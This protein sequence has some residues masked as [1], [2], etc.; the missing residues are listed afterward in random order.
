M[1]IAIYG[2]LIKKDALPYVQQMFDELYARKISSYIHEDYYPHLINNIQFREQPVL[3]NE[4]NLDVIAR[5]DY[6]FSL[7]GDGTLLDTMT[8]VRN[9]NIPVVGINIGRLGFLANVGKDEIVSVLDALEKG[10]VTHDP[11]TLIHL[12]SNVPG[13]FGEAPFALNE[14]TIHKKDSSAM[15][16]IHTYI[17]GEFLMSYWADGLIVSTP[18]GSTGYSLSCGGPI[19]FPGSENFVITPVAPHNLNIRPIVVSD[20]SVISFEIEGRSDHFLVTLDSRYESVDSSIQLAVRKEDFTVT[21]I[22]PNEQHFLD[23]LRN[24]LSLG[25]DQRN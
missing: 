13:L 16:V 18:T 8:I 11:R 5:L 19:I 15:I 6:I 10:A 2:R 25:L 14:F 3:F 22:R 1:H 9:T 7:G 4:R 23:T 21:L 20:N 12:D 17:N 24:K